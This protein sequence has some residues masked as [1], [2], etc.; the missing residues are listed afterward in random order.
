[1]VEH[2]AGAPGLASIVAQLAATA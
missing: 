2:R 1:M